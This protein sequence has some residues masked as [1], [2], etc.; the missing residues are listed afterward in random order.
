MIVMEPHVQRQQC[1]ETKDGLEEGSN[2]I[3]RVDILFEGHFDIQFGS[4]EDQ[5]AND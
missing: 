1:R 4:M 5:K 2:I 3:S